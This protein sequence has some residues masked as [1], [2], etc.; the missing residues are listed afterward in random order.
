MKVSTTVLAAGVRAGAHWK[1]YRWQRAPR[2][3]RCPAEVV[4][5]FFR[6]AT[7]TRRATP[8]DQGPMMYLTPSASMLLGARG[9]ARL[10]SSSR[11]MYLMVFALDL[12]A[13][14]SRA[15]FIPRRG[16]GLRRK[17]R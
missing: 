9:A 17:G 6:L 5:V 2:C 14:S 15:I 7:R 10:V 1:E 16:R 4:K 12:H 11:V 13:A 3:P 8:E